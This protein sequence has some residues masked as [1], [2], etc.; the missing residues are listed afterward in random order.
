LDIKRKDEI[1]CYIKKG[2]FDVLL[3]TAFW[4][5]CPMLVS[6]IFLTYTLLGYQMTSEVAFTTMMIGYLL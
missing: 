6:A 3:N 5:T 1:D 4:L 2:F